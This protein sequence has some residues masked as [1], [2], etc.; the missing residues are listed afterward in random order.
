VSDGAAGPAT[1]RSWSA[2]GAGFTVLFAATGV[3]F[4]FGIL[5]KSI[6]LELG[7]DRSTL[8]L[9]VTA[10][11]LVNALGQPAFG[12]L[13]D[14]FGPRRVVL[15]SMAL[16]VA[17]TG[18]VAVAEQVWQVILLYGVVAAAGYTGS[19]ILP[20]SVHVARWFPGERGFVTAVAACG[21]SLGQLVFA[22]VAAGLAAAV[23]WRSTY[24][25]LAGILAA[26]L[27]GI[28]I[29]LRDAG[30]AAAGR[31]P[32]AAPATAGGPSLSRRDAL[33]TVGFWGLTLGLMGCGFTDFLLTTHLAPFATD[34]G[35][36]T[37]AAANALSLWAAANVVGILLAGGIAA[38][39][40]SRTALVITYLVR[41]SALFW[42]LRVREEWQLYVFAILFGATFFTTAPLSSTMVGQL[43][44]PTHHG[45]IFGAANFFHHTA[46]ALGSWAGGLAFDLTRSYAGIFL[47]SGVVVLGSATASAL[48]RPPRPPIAA[49]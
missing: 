49:R 12:G 43:F 18:L 14:R 44:G 2:L 17:G 42:L 5:F 23:G 11:L 21:F 27:P 6:L 10:S 39:L 29:W 38:R 30:P 8:A 1:P 24:A 41:A 20:I 22:Q 35:L 32:G 40:G 36:S 19:G 37:G 7:S 31:P 45:A 26:F 28:A 33:A 9:A 48:A 15:P 46:G 4:S 13:V 3:H 16:L 47:A 34:L 25:A